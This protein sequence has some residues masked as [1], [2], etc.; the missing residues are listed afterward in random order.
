[1]FT[2]QARIHYWGIAWILAI[3]FLVFSMKTAA[4]VA[5]CTLPLNYYMSNRIYRSV[6]EK[7]KTE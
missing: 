6:Y 7:K 1:M 5:L 3:A 2:V 4:I